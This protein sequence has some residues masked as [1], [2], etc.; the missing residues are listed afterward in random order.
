M[1]EINTSSHDSNECSFYIELMKKGLRSC[2]FIL[3]C[4]CSENRYLVF[5]LRVFLALCKKA[6]VVVAVLVVSFVNHI[7]IIYVEKDI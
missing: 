2:I 1:D 7:R 4:E 5:I 3:G 6:E